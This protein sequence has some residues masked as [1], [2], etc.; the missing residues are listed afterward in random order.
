MAQPASNADQSVTL[1][2]VI[3]RGCDLIQLCFEAKRIGHGFLWSDTKR[4]SGRGAILNS[5]LRAMGRS[6]V[7][8]ASFFLGLALLFCLVAGFSLA[9]PC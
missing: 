6:A 2:F 7:S 5:V 9:T 8:K 4:P 1:P 3:P